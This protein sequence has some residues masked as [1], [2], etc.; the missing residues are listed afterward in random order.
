MTAFLPFNIF[1]YC[2]VSWYRWH[3]IWWEWVNLCVLVCMLKSRWKIKH[4]THRKFRLL[5]QIF[6]GLFSISKFFFFF[7]FFRFFLFDFYLSV[8]LYPYF[9]FSV[10]HRVSIPFAIFFSTVICLNLYIQKKKKYYSYYFCR[11][12]RSTKVSTF[13][14]IYDLFLFLS[15]KIYNKNELVISR[16]HWV[17]N[18]VMHFCSNEV[19]LIHDLN[20]LLFFQF[21][22]R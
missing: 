6:C 7:G 13:S 5:K 17:C 3:F 2:F 15:L 16:C 21:V 22:W 4:K 11:F 8:V 20:A 14:L 19:P 1:E 18:L 12:L 10:L 9:L